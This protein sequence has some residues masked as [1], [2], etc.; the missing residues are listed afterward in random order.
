M[1]L[2]AKVALGSLGAYVGV[3]LYAHARGVLGVDPA[4]GSPRHPTSGTM[5]PDEIAAYDSLRWRQALSW[6]YTKL[7]APALFLGRLEAA[8]LLPRLPR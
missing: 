4:V 6:P 7:L 2:L 1:S 3:A 8:N 5:T